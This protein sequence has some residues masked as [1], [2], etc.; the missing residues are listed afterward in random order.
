MQFKKGNTWCNLFRKLYKNWNKKQMMY[1]ETNF[2]TS[3]CIKNCPLIIVVFF[4]VL[5]L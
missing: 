2:F 4:I 5:V 1:K 3:F